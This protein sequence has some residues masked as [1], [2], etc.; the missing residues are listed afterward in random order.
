MV[1]E[2]GWAVLEFGCSAREFGC[3][4]LELGRSAREFGR[5]ALEL[6]RSA[7]EFGWVALEFRCAALEFGVP[8]ATLQG[9]QGLGFLNDV[10]IGSGRFLP[11]IC[12]WVLHQ[13]MRLP[14]LGGVRY[15]KLD[16]STS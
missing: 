12:M 6:G 7:R 4:V 10:E 15:F 9:V 5:V 14:A 1:L 16:L 13:P 11:S 8:C 3:V 2:F